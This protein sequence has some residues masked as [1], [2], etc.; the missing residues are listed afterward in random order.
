GAQAPATPPMPPATAPPDAAPP[1]TAPP[2]TAPPG[3]AAPPA[4]SARVHFSPAQVETSWSNNITVALALDGGTDVAAAPMQIQFDPKMLRLNDVARGDFLSSDNQPA[5]FT[6]NI[7][8]DTGTVAIQLNRMPGTPG[9][10]GSGVL[11]TMTFQAVG[12][13]TTVVSVPNLSV[14]NSQGQV[15]A[16]ASPQLAVNVK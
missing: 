4:G 10:N 16:T 11:V 9:V 12:R 8:N 6:K 2:A 7:M 13:G 5:V 1:A 3:D 15:I 14:R